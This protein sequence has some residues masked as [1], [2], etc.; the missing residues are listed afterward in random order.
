MKDKPPSILSLSQI[1]FFSLLF[2]FIR[3]ARLFLVQRNIQLAQIYK[4]I[5]G[6]FFA[7]KINR[8]YIIAIER[9][10]LSFV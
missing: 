9:L 4:N 1:K 6:G 10:S 3:P 7:C 2:D 5:K 8:P